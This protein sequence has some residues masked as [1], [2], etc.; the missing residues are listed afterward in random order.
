MSWGF[1]EQAVSVTGPNGQLIGVFRPSP[2]P[3]GPI[4]LI[5]AG[6]PFTRY[7][8]HRMFHQLARWLADRGISSLRI[9]CGGWGDSPGQSGILEHSVD[10]IVAALHYLA[11]EHPERPLVLI[12]LNE[13]AA[14]AILAVA[15]TELQLDAE[16]IA[17]IALI[18]PWVRSERI[19]TAP[20]L[21]SEKTPGFFSREFWAR[22]FRRKPEPVDEHSHVQTLSDA[23]LAALQVYDQRVLTVLAGDDPT[24]DDTED[25]IGSDPRWRT[26]LGNSRNL[27]RVPG[28]DHTFSHPDHWRHVCDWL[29]SE[30]SRQS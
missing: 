1:D 30:L 17:D 20:A 11:R 28:A 16:R 3:T 4:A 9:D 18:N 21:R 22:L 29:S 14:A 7:G 10:D 27:L 15:S 6:R 19:M 26:R 5:A 24:A 8:P 13:G 25:L 12:G 23:L 2:I